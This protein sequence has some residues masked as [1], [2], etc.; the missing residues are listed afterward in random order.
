M[1]LLTYVLRKFRGRFA[2]VGLA[3]AVTVVLAPAMANPAVASNGGPAP[4]H[5][6]DKSVP[7]HAVAGHYAA[8][9]PMPKW[10]PTTPTWPSGSAD[11][12]LGAASTAA[13]R[14]GSLPVRLAKTAA[15]DAAPSAKV[16]VGSK[17]AADAAGVH[18]VV[19][20]VQRTDS[21][22]KPSKVHVNVDY[23]AFRDAFGGDWASRLRL[24]QLPVCALSTPSKPECRKETPV[25][26][27][28]DVKAGA[29][30]GDV[31]LPVNARSTKSAQLVLAADSSTSGSG[32]DYGAT[33]LKPSGA[34]QAGGSADAFSWSYPVPV[35][36]VPGGLVPKVELDYNSQAV[37]GMTSSTNNQASWIGDGWDYSPGYIERSYQSCHQNPAGPTQTADMCWSDNNTLTMSLNGSSTTLVRDDATGAYR[38]QNA[39]NDKVQYQTGAS[40]GARN[41]EYFTVTGTDGTQYVFGLNHLPGLDPGDAKS[42]PTNSTWTVP[43]FATAAIQPCYNATFADSHCMQAYRWN[44]DYVKDT[45][46]DVVSYFYN[47]ESNNYASHLADQA[48]TGYT[49]GGYLSKI[50]Y[51]QRDGGVYTTSPAAQVLFSSTGRCTGFNCDPAKDLTATSAKDWPDVPYDLTCAM[52]ADCKGKAPAFWT[53]YTLQG[54]ETDVLVGTTETK[55]DTWALGHDFPPTGDSTTASLWLSSITHIGQ[56]TTGAGSTAPVALPA[57]NFTGTALANRVNLNSGYSPITRHRL[58]K[59]TTETGETVSVD[60]SAP[61][62]ASGTP[63][64]ESNASLCFP[65]YWTPPD[66]ADPVR[67]WFNKFV[68]TGVEE[69]D[70]LDTSSKNGLHTTYTPIGTPAWHHNDNP[71]TPSAQRTFDQW[72]GYPGMIVTKGANPAIKT[73]YTYYRG[74]A[75]QTPPKPDGVASLHTDTPPADAEQFT[76]D[77]YETVTYSGDAV[78]T[79]TVSDPWTSVALA[80]HA[81]TELPAQQVF[82]TGTADTKTFTPL[83]RGG[84]RETETDNTFDSYGR[85]TKVNDQG[86]VSTIADDLCTTTSFNDNTDKWIL[87]KQSEVDTV[88]AKCDTKPTL[89]DNAVSDAF[90]FYDGATS[91]STPPTVGDATMTQRIVSYTNGVADPPVTLGTT[92]PDQYGRPTVQTD[93]NGKQTK[94]SY[95]PA[96]GAAPTTV[97]TTDPMLLTTSVTFDAVRNLPLVKTDAGGYKTNLQ[98]DTLGRLTAVFKPGVPDAATKYSYTVSNSGPSVVDTYSLNVDG[99]YRVGETLYDALLRARETQTQTPDNG[100]T[101]TDTEY[102]DAGLVSETTDPYFNS[103]AV[104]T[105]YVRAAASDVLSATGFTYDGAGRKTSA[106]ANANGSQTWQTNYVYGGDFTTT[107]PPAGAPATT[108]ITDAHDRT[109]DLYTY[110]SG[111]PADPSDPAA[112]YSATHYAYYANGMQQAVVDAAGNSWSYQYN[113]MGLQTSS[114]DPDTG[115]ITRTYDNAGRVTTQTDVRGKQTTFAY[116]DDNRKTATYDTT[117]VKTLTSANQTAGWTYDTVKKGYQTSTTSYSAG[118]TY[119]QTVIAYN[120]YGSAGAVK[121]TLTGEPAGLVPAG[122]LITGYGFSGEGFPTDVNYAAVDGLPNED[123]TTGYDTFGEPTSLKGNVVNGS[124]GNGA[125]W[126][127][128]KAVGYSEYGQPKVYTL[129]GATGDVHVSEDYDAQTRALTEVKTDTPNTPTVDDLTYTYSGAGVSQGAGLVTSTKDQQ[130]DGAVTDTQCFSYDYAARIAGA[131]TATDNCSATPA[132][133][134]A[135]TVGGPSAYW[136][137][138]TY[139]AAGNRATQ[140]DHDTTGDQSKDTATTYNYPSQGSASDQPNTL[141]NTTATGPNAAT[142]TGTYHYDA[143]GNTT[144]ITGGPTGN[145]TLTWNDQGKLATDTTSTGLS[146]YVY[147]ADGNLIVRRDPGKTTFF[148]GSEQLTLDTTTHTTMGCRYYAIGGVTIAMRASNVSSGNPQFLVPDRQGTDQLV[149]DSGTYQVTRR[150][151]LPFG[152]PRGTVPTTW[153]GDLGYVGGTPD[154]ATQLENL[155]AREYNPATGRFLSIDPVLE[156][157]DPTQL[158]GYDY[159]GND[160]VTGSDPTGLF[161]DP[162][163]PACGTPGGAQ[164]WDPWA[165]S[166]GTSA[167]GV[168]DATAVAACPGKRACGEFPEKQQ[169]TRGRNAIIESR[170]PVWQQIKDYL[171]VPAMLLGITDIKH[172]AEN[173]ELGSCAMAVISVVPLLKPLKALELL[174]VADEV[175]NAT[176]VAKAADDADKGGNLLKDGKDAKKVTAKADRLTMDFGSV[177][178]VA[179]KYGIDVDNVVIKFNKAIQNA[180][181]LT[182]KDGTITLYRDA[183]ASE[184]ELAKTLVHELHH[185]QQLKEGMPYPRYYDYNSPWEKAARQAEDD[186][187]N[188]HPLN[189]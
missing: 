176:K 75:G 77:A 112:D 120:Q 150:Q 45:H 119:T 147:D 99:S 174:K 125:T 89:P 48:N 153:P 164:C 107:I 35:P 42:T 47:T 158:N 27:T 103:G 72:R 167:A 109:T 162:A 44:L 62:C 155:G 74:M 8:P 32:G 133:G 56:D 36:T 25:P 177:Y 51:G 165:D 83:A 149:I 144:Q 101:I 37:D 151:F 71:L 127:F 16:D 1:A 143:A 54:I 130:N 6:N 40:N 148:F 172:C 118:D 137:S 2:T 131:W 18:G 52:G 134:N 34:W 46:N 64:P 69:D 106:V 65:T 68:V 154:P 63:N 163:G 9:P 22:A 117:D 67:D 19:F 28:N 124:P 140:V 41:G 182:S 81:L 179:D 97:A 111:V 96:T 93:A 58:W 180:S 168:D 142:N 49:R 24:V 178:D 38:A 33:S 7:V 169:A 136:Q 61:G 146:S 141:S 122:G 132:P 188:N 55:S 102:N 173:P 50:Q 82:L 91:L 161:R 87:N 157:T 94:T 66:L 79:D 116:D 23:G 108:K 145:Q 189:K 17:Q 121:T 138:W 31:T 73:E 86:D 70:P 30:G 13:V 171:Y 114:T 11:V 98:Y 181:G 21:G 100:R 166:P 26:S 113:L 159:A 92:T 3:V 175:G 95:T 20:S 185:V 43:V 78:V 187:W 10:Q 60:Y 105:T 4:F 126:L 152:A 183:F 12:T 135:A 156:V 115:T 59:V 85:V 128:V 57:V 129:T 123:V 29:V 184:E 110:H 14:A 39:P 15:A 5:P 80:T 84:V 186:F 88:A 76:G 90:T 139:D 53:N 170:K 104:S 160:P